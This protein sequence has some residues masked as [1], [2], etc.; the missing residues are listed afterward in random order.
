MDQYAMEPRAADAAEVDQLAVLWRDAWMDAHAPVVP[1]VLVRLR[2]L[3]MFRERMAAGLA[4]VRVI[5]LP[6]APLGFNM[7]KGDELYQL[8][9]AREARGS[10]VAPRLIADAEARLAANGVATA[11][12]AC[13]IGNERAA[14]FYEKQGWRR[15]ATMTNRLET[16]EGLFELEVWRYEKRLAPRA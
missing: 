15:V 16:P 7:I 10:G 1:A 9:L 2:T 3:A 5:G 8:F 14:R 12:L 13:A 6:G 11:W 4:E